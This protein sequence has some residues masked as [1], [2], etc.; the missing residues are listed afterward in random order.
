MIPKIYHSKKTVMAYIKAKP[1]P[2]IS[3]LK[4]LR[5]EVEAIFKF[6]DLSVETRKREIVM[7]RQIFCYIAKGMRFRVEDI[8]REIRQHHSNVSVSCDSVKDLFDTGNDEFIDC[9][10]QLQTCASPWLTGEMINHRFIKKIEFIN[11]TK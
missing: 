6:E 2:P 7:V 5:S 9:W 10:N 11:E 4:Q 1:R 3:E 8:G